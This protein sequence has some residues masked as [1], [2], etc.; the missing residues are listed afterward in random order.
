[1]R[2][3]KI[4]FMD[5]SAETFS[6][7][8]QAAS[9]TVQRLRLDDF[10]QGQFAVIACESEVLVFPL[11]NIKALRFTLPEDAIEGLHLPPSAIRGAEPR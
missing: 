6:F 5:G 11:A 8:V 1:M 7:P 2:F 10:V 3:I 4:E 9:P